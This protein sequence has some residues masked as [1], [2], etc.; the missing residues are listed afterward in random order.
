MWVA[1]ASYSAQVSI[2]PTILI[3]TV[4]GLV[5]AG[6]LV[7]TLCWCRPVRQDA[8]AV[9][10]RALLLVMVVVSMMCA[11]PA[12]RFAGGEGCPAI[13]DVSVT[14]REARAATAWVHHHIAS[15]AAPFT[16]TALDTLNR[17]FAHCGG[18][19][20][21]LDKILKAS[22]IE[23]RIVHFEN[24]HR[25]HTLVEYREGTA[26]WLLAD[27]QNNILGV[28]YGNVSGWALLTRP[29]LAEPPASW[30]GYL[31]LYIYF[32]RDGY[33]LVTSENVQEFYPHEM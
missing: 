17:G 11:R 3:Y 6:P 16:D 1:I 7:L 30:N 22:G 20:N 12:R 10:V 14:T 8:E 9:R 19:A 5:A 4:C 2:C 33:R 21:L 28:D 18:M 25:I 29:P 23:S 15:E 13:R 31:K 27:P 24:G 32:P 26:S